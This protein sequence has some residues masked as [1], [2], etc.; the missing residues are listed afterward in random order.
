MRNPLKALAFI[1]AFTFVTH[2]PGFAE[3][4]PIPTPAHDW[5]PI[6]D[7][8]MNTGDHVVG[9]ELCARP[10]KTRPELLGI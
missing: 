5:Q 7:G 2:T 6:D 4:K 8:L 1:L 9:E 3:T 10:G